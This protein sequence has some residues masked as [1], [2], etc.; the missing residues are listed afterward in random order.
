MRRRMTL[1]LARGV[2][3]FETS[4]YHVEGHS[5]EQI[6]IVSD[7]ESV[8]GEI[9]EKVKRKKHQRLLTDLLKDVTQLDNQNRSGKKRNTKRKK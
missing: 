5:E 7:G 3:M 2:F 6:E 1:T 4:K 8:K 9:S